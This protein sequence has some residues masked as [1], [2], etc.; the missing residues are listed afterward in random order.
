MLLT[1]TVHPPGGA[2][3]VL[4]AT[5]P[6]ITAMGWYFVGLV[7]WGTTLMLAV[8]L[9]INN[10]QRQFPLYWW[11]P[12][13]V[14]KA[15]IEDEETVPDARGGIE[16]KKC[17]E[18]QGYYQ[19]G[20]RI[21]INGAEVILPDDLSLNAEETKVLERLRERLRKRVDVE[22]EEKNMGKEESDSGKSSTEFTMVPSNS[23]SSREI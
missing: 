4:A 16:R 3:A 19:E 2:S 22:R 6:V 13:D 14:R 9:V 1:N 17:S 23:G 7:M 20:E 21:E 10:I 8:G 5:E 15:R 18:E 12:L 11:T